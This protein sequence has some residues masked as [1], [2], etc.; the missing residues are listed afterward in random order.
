[1]FENREPMEEILIATPLKNVTQ[2]YEFSNGISVRKVQPILWEQSTVKG[3]I[4]ENDKAYISNTDLWL[5][6]GKTVDNPYGQGDELYETLHWAM[7]GAQMIC[8]VGGKNLYL[9]FHHTKDG[10]DNI[11][12]YHPPELNSS[13]MGRLIY[14]EK[15]GFE[16]GFET[17]Y[18]R[19]EPSFHRKDH[20]ASEPDS[21]T[22][23][24]PT[25]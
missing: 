4:S 18:K 15:Q 7:Y 10:F 24:W 13:T 5:T 1:M 3:F 2:P 19:R 9:K 21:S 14:L 8:P 20:Q 6:I 12:I 16:Q 23:A 22:R 25:N 11:G 17:V